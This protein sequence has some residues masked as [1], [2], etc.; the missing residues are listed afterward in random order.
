MS[1]VKIDGRRKLGELA[2]RASIYGPQIIE[3]R[4]AMITR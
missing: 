1:L 2:G 3:I 4:A